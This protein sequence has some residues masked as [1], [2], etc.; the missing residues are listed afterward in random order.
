MKYL[1][2]NESEIYPKIG[3][4]GTKVRKGIEEIFSKYGFNVK[5]TGDGNPICENSSF[6]GV[7]FLKEEIDR[8]TSPD[9]AWNPEVSDCE[10]REK[11]FKLA[12]LGEGFNVFHGYGAI[13][14]AHSDKEIQASLD[15][16]ERIA[17]K[18]SE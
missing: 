13:S 12:M 1:I 17:I 5:C 6:I 10:L 8:V 2:E 4:L 11:I 16:V 3:R 7:H 14:A 9:E 18:W 15:A